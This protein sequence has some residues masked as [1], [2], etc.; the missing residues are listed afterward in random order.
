MP[1]TEINNYN[2]MIDGQN[3]SDQPV[4]SNIRTYNNILK[5][6]TCQRDD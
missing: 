5:I 2:L 6:T 4:K 3:F 1:T